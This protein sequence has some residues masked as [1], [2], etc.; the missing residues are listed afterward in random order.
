M[1]ISFLNVLELICLHIS[2]AIVSTQ[3]NGFNYCY[4]THNSIQHYSF[5]CTQLNGSKWIWEWEHWRGTL[6]SPKLY[7]ILEPHNCIDGDLHTWA[8]P[9]RGRWCGDKRQVG[10]FLTSSQTQK[11]KLNVSWW[12]KNR[13]SA[14]AARPFETFLGPVSFRSFRKNC[15]GN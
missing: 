13:L 10:L 4:Q 1:V 14:N 5:I 9:C 11:P 2:I 3:L 7:H 15:I 8:D 12:V 6:Y